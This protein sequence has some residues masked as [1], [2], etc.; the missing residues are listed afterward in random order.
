[1]IF[2]QISWWN[3][4]NPKGTSPKPNDAVMVAKLNKTKTSDRDN[5]IY[6]L[7][8]KNSASFLQMHSKL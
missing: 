7:G 3:H 2:A 6:P 1:M 4:K 5:M 8:E